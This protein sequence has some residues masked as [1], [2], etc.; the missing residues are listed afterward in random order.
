[1]KTLK[2]LTQAF[3]QFVRNPSAKNY[4]ELEKCI[5]EYQ[6]ENK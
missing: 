3:A 5:L 4:T 2:E 1:M 6:R